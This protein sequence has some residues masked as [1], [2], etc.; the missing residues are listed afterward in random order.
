MKRGNIPL[1]L[2]CSGLAAGAL[3]AQAAGGTAAP[4]W[5]AWPSRTLGAGVLLF[6]LW[7]AHRVRIRHLACEM[8]RRFQ[9][10]L[11][12]RIHAACELDDSLLQ[13]L[14]SASMQLDIAVDRLPADSPARPQFVHILELMSRVGA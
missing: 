7:T 10:R 14:L 1:L 11:R 8:D 13:G 4:W 6:A 5:D 9:E 12:E 2:W 3:Q